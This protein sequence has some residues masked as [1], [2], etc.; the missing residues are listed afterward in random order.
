LAAVLIVFAWAAWLLLRDATPLRAGVTVLLL[1]AA[2]LA[3]TQFVTGYTLA[4]VLAPFI[5]GGLSCVAYFAIT[6][7]V[8]RR[9]R[10]VAA[11]GVVIPAIGLVITGRGLLVAVALASGT[12]SIFPAAEGRISPTASYRI[13]LRHSLWG[14]TPYY[15]FTIEKNPRWFPLIEKEAAIG[16]LP[17][18][19]G[20]HDV[21]IGPGRDE[22]VVQITCRNPGPG[23]RPMEVLLH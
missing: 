20:P 22:H 10:I 12:S 9:S 18:G 8:W 2:L 23:D 6:I 15:G 11:L 4:S 21:T 16:A 19:S 5:I 1:I 14:A 7:A 13:F 3:P 17:C